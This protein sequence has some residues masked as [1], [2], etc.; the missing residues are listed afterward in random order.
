MFQLTC[1]TIINVLE[2]DSVIKVCTSNLLRKCD[3]GMMLY[4]LKTKTSFNICML[5][6]SKIHHSENRC[7]G[8]WVLQYFMVFHK[9]YERKS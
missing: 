2:T 4:A 9:S 1:L 5:Y 3:F 6:N 8:P 7:R